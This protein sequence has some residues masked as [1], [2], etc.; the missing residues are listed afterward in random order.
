MSCVYHPNRDSISFCD[1]CEAALCKSCTIYLEDGRTLCHRCILAV[2]LEDVKSETTLR[3]QEE[4][5]RRVGLQKEWRPSYIHLVLA[6][7]LAGILILLALSLYWS[8]NEAR[9]R[10]VLDM[11]GPVE[12]LAALQETLANY[13]VDHGNSYPDSLYELIP[14]YLPDLGENRT[15]LQYLEYDLDEKRG[16]LLRI[17]ADSPLSGENLVATKMD[18]YPTQ[19]EE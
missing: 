5:D 18:I 2:S 6:V 14:T 11:S 9:P 1:H 12:L 7:G 10:V 8:Q 13:A 19:T 15:A 17:K 16:Y 3:E 4:E